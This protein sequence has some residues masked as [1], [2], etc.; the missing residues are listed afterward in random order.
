MKQVSELPYA[1]YPLPLAKI[2]GVPLSFVFN[3]HCGRTSS[4]S[5]IMFSKSLSLN[6]Q[7]KNKVAPQPFTRVPALP[8]KTTFSRKQYSQVSPL[9]GWRTPLRHALLRK[10]FGLMRELLDKGADPNE[11]FFQR[12]KFWDGGSTS[13]CKTKSF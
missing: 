11:R 10:D 8:T 1:H 9:I 3:W 12:I 4:F 6:F 7:I 5:K 13:V 2:I